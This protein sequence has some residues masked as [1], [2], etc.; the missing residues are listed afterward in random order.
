MAKFFGSDSPPEVLMRVSRMLLVVYGF[1]DASGGGFGSSIEFT[2]G[3]SYRV[4]VYGSDMEGESSNF[5][6]LSN[7]VLALEE[8]AATGSLND[9]VVFF[10]TDNATVEAA[11][12]KGTSS[13]R[14]LLELVIRFYELQAKYGITIHVSHVS[15]KR[16]IAQGT[17][18]LSRGQL[19]EGVMNGGSV[20]RD[21]VP[22]HLSALDR[23]S[24]LPQWVDS[25]AGSTPLV[26]TPTD[27]FE[28]GHDIDGGCTGVDGFWRPVVS[29]GTY[30]WA[31]PPAAA[32]VALEQLRTARIKRQQSTHIFICPRLMTPMWLKQLH[33]ASDLIFT[34][35]AGA[36]CWPEPMFEPLLIGVVFPFLSFSPWQLKGTPKLLALGRQLSRVWKVEQMDKGNI[37]REFC[38]LRERMESM[39]RDVVRGLLH[40]QPKANFSH[41]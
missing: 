23:T 36:S 5:R 17:D 30:L 34:I 28:R 25:W 27:W 2:R 1:R 10:F 13:N 40:F 19:N 32:D 6:E 29:P 39:P 31:P 3:I 9:A 22:L 41:I 18:G 38:A 37:L 7:V 4:G 16:M 26:L 11:L 15:G 33:K 8:E 24:G 21:F 35:P 12:Y 14:K 20:M